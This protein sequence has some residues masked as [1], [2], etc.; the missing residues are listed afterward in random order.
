MNTTESDISIQ[1]YL[2]NNCLVELVNSYSLPYGHLIFNNSNFWIKTRKMTTYKYP[3]IKVK[4]H[5]NDQRLEIFELKD[6]WLTYRGMS[7]C[8]AD[9]VDEKNFLT[10][11]F[12]KNNDEIILEEFCVKIVDY[13]YKLEIFR[14]KYEYLEKM[15]HLTLRD[16]CL[17]DQS[18]IIRRNNHFLMIIG[19]Y[20]KKHLDENQ[21]LDFTQPDKTYIYAYK[22]KIEAYN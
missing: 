3:N 5:N 15:K 10:Y 4:N 14:N 9:A 17:F 19:K 1:T 13:F 22:N 11:K 2:R 16:N 20:S 21:Q 6:G 18:K 12:T 7:L 8:Q